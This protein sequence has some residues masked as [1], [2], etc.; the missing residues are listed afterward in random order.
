MLKC[1][2]VFFAEQ[3]ASVNEKLWSRDGQPP[4]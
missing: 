1:M 4:I 2:K 3:S